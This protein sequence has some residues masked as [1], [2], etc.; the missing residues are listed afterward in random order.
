MYGMFTN[1]TC[2]LQMVIPH[3]IVHL[4][5]I[6]TIFN[7]LSSYFRFEMLSMHAD[8]VHKVTV[9]VFLFIFPG[10]HWVHTHLSMHADP[11]KTG[12]PGAYESRT[13]LRPHRGL[14]SGT[15]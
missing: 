12:A 11:E 1:Y 9:P 13:H 2:T 5:F 7:L 3:L 14:Q 8:N 4:Y 15:Q 6:G 10:S